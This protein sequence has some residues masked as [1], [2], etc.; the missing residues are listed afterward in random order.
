MVGL[1]DCTISTVTG[2]RVLSKGIGFPIL[3]YGK[4]RANGLFVPGLFVSAA[5]GSG[6]AARTVLW[7]AAS[8][9]QAEHHHKSQQQTRDLLLP[10]SSSSFL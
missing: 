3:I 6:G 1:M 7:P 8:G 10:H 4:V 9:K 5:R 2:F